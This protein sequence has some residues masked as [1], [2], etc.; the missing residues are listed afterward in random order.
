MRKFLAV[1]GTKIFPNFCNPHLLSDFLSAAY[2]SGGMNGVLALE[3]LFILIREYNLDFPEFYDNLYAILDASIFYASYRTRL[4]KLVGV[5]MSSTMLPAYVVAGIVKRVSRLCLTA[6]PA[7]IIW[8]IPFSYNLLWK[9]PACRV[10]IHRDVPQNWVDP[11]NPTETSLA[12]CRALESCLW[13]LSSLESHVWPRVAK[14]STLF[15]EKFSKPPFDLD[16]IVKEIED[17]Q[18][19]KV[20]SE[21]LSHKWTRRPPTCIT[22]NGALFDK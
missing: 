11:Y 9:Y 7:A 8:A 15:C 12:N 16:S 2:R 19:Q 22:I 14:L 5:F 20:A 3:G 18:L 4:L 1:L 6:P 21:E 17:I 10:M 13:E